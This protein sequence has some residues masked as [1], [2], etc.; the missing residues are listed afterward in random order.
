[1]KS[2]IIRAW[3]AAAILIGFVYI[4]L[5]D[6]ATATG[7]WGRWLPA[8]QFMPA[9]LTVFAGGTF[10]ALLFLVTLTLLCG[11]VY[12]AVL[13][14]LGILQ[15]LFIFLSK[16]SGRLHFTYQQGQAIIWYGLALLTTA[17]FVG[18]SMV[19]VELLDPYSFFARTA[20]L[21]LKPPATLLTNFG[22]GL[23][24]ALDIYWAAPVKL[25]PLPFAVSIFC[26]GC[27]MTL[28]W[29]AYFHGRWYCTA[30]CPVGALL[31]LCAKLA[32]FNVRIDRDR[33]TTCGRC[34]RRCRAY[35][36]DAR[37]MRIDIDRCVSC[38]DCLD[39]C[40]EDALTYGWV[41]PWRRLAPPKEDAGRRRFLLAL[42][43][44]GTGIGSG[45]ATMAAPLATPPELP[46]TPPGS[47]GFANFTAQCSA[48]QLCVG[49]CPTKVLQPALFAYGTG[50]L[51]QP[52]MDFNRSRC[53]YECNACSL[54]CP[55]AAI[56][57]VSL[58]AKKRIQIGEVQ[59]LTEHC[60]VY[61]HKRDCGACAEV[62]PTHAVYTILEKGV[63]LPKLKAEACT[64][65]GACQHV[66][67]T[68]PKSILVRPKREHATAAPPFFQTKPE[69]DGTAPQPAAAQDFPF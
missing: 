22:I 36:I 66:C 40:P 11:R 51:L 28:V 17:V 26:F 43:G 1:M 27:L 31:G 32:L 41:R 38:L 63:H 62:C 52:A 24:E 60:I 29:L 56:R 8:F 25:V 45:A 34:E 48:C 65:C 12:C 50:G 35:C 4:L 69:P 2:A 23:L 19:L 64:G 21:L 15:D 10:T 67:P 18:G 7:G 68:H 30:I 6:T 47:L 49:I 33:C 13:C 58:V 16:K 59:L 37:A 44:L 3:V 46:A 42:L 55:T 53:D 61:V 20:V 9:L 5:G 14:P 39:L 54:V 57:P